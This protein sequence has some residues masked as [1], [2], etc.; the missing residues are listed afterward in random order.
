MPLSATIPERI[1]RMT[2][3]RALS[4]SFVLL[5]PAVSACGL[6]GRITHGEETPLFPVKKNGR[7]GFIDRS[8]QIAITPRFDQVWHFS[9][10]RA[11]EQ[12]GYI[13]RRG[14]LVI[15]PRFEDAWYFA[16]GLALVQ[17][18]GK[19]GYINKKGEYVWSPTE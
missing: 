7:W 10:G 17:V 3:R 6:I 18:D 13:N 11:N 8:G 14:K 9:D 15:E 19:Y 2:L 4:L 5:L 12:F 1:F 16:H